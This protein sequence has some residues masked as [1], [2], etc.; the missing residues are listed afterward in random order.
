[1]YNYSFHT[2]LTLL[3]AVTAASI[4]KVPIHRSRPHTYHHDRAKQHNFR[5]HRYLE[6]PFD[7]QDEQSDPETPSGESNPESSTPGFVV[8]TL[9]LDGLGLGTDVYSKDTSMEAY[10]F[11]FN[12]LTVTEPIGVLRFDHEIDLETFAAHAEGEIDYDPQKLPPLA[13]SPP[14]DPETYYFLEEGIGLVLDPFE[15][16]LVV[17]FAEALPGYV[18]DDVAKELFPEGPPAADTG[19]VE[20]FQ[21]TQ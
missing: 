1:M 6:D 5:K 14:E 15:D 18:S 20:D 3:S 19:I 8:S 11:P 12:E 21:H 16:E 17:E 7:E 10:R 13:F 2:S 9:L 4:K